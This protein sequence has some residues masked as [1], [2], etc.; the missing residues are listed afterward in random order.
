MSAS[1]SIVELSKS[2]SHMRHVLN[3][4][5]MFGCADHPFGED[6]DVYERALQDYPAL[7]KQLLIEDARDI[8][9]LANRCDAFINSKEGCV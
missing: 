9:E 7:L 5:H 3:T 2:A 6:I 1:M 4:L 8:M